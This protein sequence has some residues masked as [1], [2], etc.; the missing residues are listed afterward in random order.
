MKLFNYS[1]PHP[2]LGHNDDVSDRFETSYEIELGKRKTVLH[3][4]IILTNTTLKQL[5]KLK[6][7]TFC[8]DISCPN[9]LFR[10]NIVFLPQKYDIELESNFLRGKVNVIFYIIA[11][12]PI[13]E[14]LPENLNKDYSGY[15][16]SISKSE[17][18]AI[19]E[20]TWF[21][22]DKTYEQ[23][24]SVSSLFQI[25][26]SPEKDRVSYQFD[27]DKITIN[28][29][30]KNFNDYNDIINYEIFYSAYHAFL[31]LPALTLALEEVFSD[32]NNLLQN[33]PWYI[34]ILQIRENNE[35]IKRIAIE[36]NNGHVLAQHILKLPIGRSLADLRM[37]KDR[38]SIPN[39]E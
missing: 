14:Y 24:F 23:F 38:L 6:K 25:C 17:E 7:V 8:C 13:P 18:L 19:G 36:K 4:D 39:N 10:K 30:S 22:A 26:K 15:K 5:L 29:P 31:A 12:E 28:L 35:S 3:V 16:F 9:T 34:K 20:K 2:V 21:I 27:E 1:F 33:K 32:I 37:L 11:L